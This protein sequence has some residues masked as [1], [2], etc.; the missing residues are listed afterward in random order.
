MSFDVVVDFDFLFVV[1]HLLEMVQKDS[2]R[3]VVHGLPYEIQRQVKEFVIGKGFNTTQV[4]DIDSSWLSSVLVKHE[5]SL[6]LMSWVRQL[7][8]VG[9]VAVQGFSH[10][11]L[12]RPKALAHFLVLLANHRLQL[13]LEAF[14]AVEASKYVALIN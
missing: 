6:K 7:Q 11:V 8:E 14:A 2:N 1:D 13:L 10:H 3:C 12:D 4:E 5:E 9:V